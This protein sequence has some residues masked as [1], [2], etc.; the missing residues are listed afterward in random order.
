MKVFM[1]RRLFGALQHPV[2]KNFCLP[3]DTK[4]QVYIINNCYI[5]NDEMYWGVM[6]HVMN[7]N[8]LV[9]GA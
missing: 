3:V 6:D 4:Q 7:S 2:F 8:K 1:R 9:L 5:D